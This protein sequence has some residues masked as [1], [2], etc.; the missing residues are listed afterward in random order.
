MR[1]ADRLSGVLFISLLIVS[2]VRGDETTGGEIPVPSSAATFRDP[3]LQKM[4]ALD[5]I[6]PFEDKAPLWDYRDSGLQQQMEAVLDKRRIL[7]LYFNVIEWGPGIYGIRRLLDQVRVPQTVPVDRT[8]RRNTYDTATT[9]VEAC[10]TP[11]IDDR[12]QIPVRVFAPA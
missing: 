10:I 9:E 6:A 1:W 3:Q 5:A 11:G 7:E 12:A 2:P 4:W 8:V